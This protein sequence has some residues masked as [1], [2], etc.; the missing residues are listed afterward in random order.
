LN[1]FTVDFNVLR[2]FIKSC[3]WSYFKKYNLLGH[4]GLGWGY[5]V[6]PENEKYLLIKRDWNPIYHSDWKNL[7]KI[8]TR[9]LVVHARKDYPWKKNVNNI[10]PIN[11]GEKYVITHNGTIKNSSFPI[12]NH[13]PLE[14]I[15]NHTQLDTRKYLC[16]IMDEL[17][18]NFNLRDALIAIFKNI[19][20]GL[21]A[22]A[23]LFNTTE[24]NIIKR[25][26]DK[27]SARHTTLFLLKE[28][29]SIMAATTPLKP[30][31]KEIPNNTLISINLSNLNTKMYQL[32]FNS[33][34]NF[35]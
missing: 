31:M 6:I 26:N 32:D 19:E 17:K 29:N 30:T 28:N 9:F 21:G 13:P 35:L 25:Q 34:K 4:H 3:H 33:N 24:C 1:N 11:I 23:F 18:E 14:R 2:N 12:L 5:A 22:N 15:K 16:Y 8:K 10:H 7:T 27:F 20:L